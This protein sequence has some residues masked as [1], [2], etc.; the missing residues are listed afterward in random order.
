MNFV[1]NSRHCRRH[2]YEF[3]NPRADVAS[4]S[5]AYYQQWRRQFDP[6]PQMKEKLFVISHQHYRILVRVVRLARGEIMT[7]DRLLLIHRRQIDKKTQPFCLFAIFNLVLDT[8]VYDKNDK[9]KSY[10]AI[11]S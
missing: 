9:T 1:T 3:S 2:T 4:S 6:Q 10:S 7:L 5:A 8:L 11:F